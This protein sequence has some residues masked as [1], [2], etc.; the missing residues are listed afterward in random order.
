M[1][2][3]TRQASGVGPSS[4][5]QLFFYYSD[6]TIYYLVLLL[7]SSSS[8]SLLSLSPHAPENLHE[9]HA[10]CRRLLQTI[11][12]DRWV[13]INIEKVLEYL[14]ELYKGFNGGQGAGRPVEINLLASR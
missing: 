5:R 9:C 2:A 1:Q 12:T 8:L 14:S 7:L 13:Y 10:A 3:M 4:F 6:N 11:T